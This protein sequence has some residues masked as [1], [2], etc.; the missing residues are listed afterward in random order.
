MS[1]ENWWLDFIEDEVDASTRADMKALLRASAKDQE[2]V[3]S[4]SDTKTLLKEGA[5]EPLILESQLENLHDKIMA[6]IDKKE[7]KAP[8]KLRLRLN[9]E[10]RRAVKAGSLTLALVL[11]AVYF[12]HSLS[13]KG[14]NTEWDVS[15]QMATHGI[16]NPD[17]LAQL[18]TYQNET[19]FFVDVASQSLDHLTKE[20]FESLLKSTKTR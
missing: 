10:Q 8:P 11:V 19:D 20:Q 6:G 2:L 7:I 3:K 12:G 16:E 14:L 18:M 5:S 4:I 17:E 13:N 1:R 15:R 9:P